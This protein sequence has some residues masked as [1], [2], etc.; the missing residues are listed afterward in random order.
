M[1]DQKLQVLLLHCIPGIP[2]KFSDFL[3]LEIMFIKGL[4]FRKKYVMLFTK[5]LV[6]LSRL[7][8]KI[9]VID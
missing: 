7:T 4:T 5:S 3:I 8:G 6:R 2:E 1:T 9:L